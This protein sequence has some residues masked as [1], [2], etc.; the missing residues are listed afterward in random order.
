MPESFL[1]QTPGGTLKDIIIRRAKRNLNMAEPSTSIQRVRLSIPQLGAILAGIATIV[2]TLGGSA[3]G[4]WHSIDSRF[5]E[6]E[7]HVAAQDT[8]LALVI[9][10]SEQHDKE[11]ADIRSNRDRQQAETNAKLDQINTTL[12][13]LS[14]KIAEIAVQKRP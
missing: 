3:W 13:T 11:L 12:T 8:K 9:R 7:D 2:V 14:V 1:T 10:S 4:V 5:K 6:N